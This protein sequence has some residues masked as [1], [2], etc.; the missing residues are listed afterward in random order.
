[1]VA[2]IQPDG[3]TMPETAA[4]ITALIIDRPLCF[5]CIVMRA[6]VSAAAAEVAFA[7]IT[8]VLTLR[9]DNPGRCRACGAIGVV[10]SLAQP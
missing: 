10:F 8:N 9:R 5:D 4:L 7:R 2:S 6:G 3:E 1:M